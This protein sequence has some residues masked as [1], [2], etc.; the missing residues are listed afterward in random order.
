MLLAVS[1]EL[2]RLVRLEADAIGQ[3]YAPD[4]YEDADPQLKILSALAEGTDRLVAQVGLQ[5]SW[6]LESVLPFARALYE[7]DFAEPC[8]R[9]EYRRLLSQSSSVL[10]LGYSPDDETNSGYRAVGQVLARNSD[11]LVAFWDGEPSRG[12]GGGTAD[13]VKL[14]LNESVP[15]LW[16]PQN[17]KAGGPRL[18]LPTPAGPVKTAEG[19]SWQDAVR[20]Q[21]RAMFCPSVL[22][23]EDLLGG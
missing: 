19:L 21:L 2:F 4:I 20:R 17:R 22:F 23:E 6:Q 8:S 16:L 1:D 14:A 15:V 3:R 7:R 9:Q 13:V 18:L 12:S 10:E 5:N 11:L